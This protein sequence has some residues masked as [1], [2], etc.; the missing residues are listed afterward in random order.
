MKKIFI[1]FKV[2]LKSLNLN[3]LINSKLSYRLYSKEYIDNI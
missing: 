3:G 2:R 1:A